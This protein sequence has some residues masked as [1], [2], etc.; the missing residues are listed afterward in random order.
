MKECVFLAIWI[1]LTATLVGRTTL[2][3]SSFTA[4]ALVG[5]HDHPT[6]DEVTIVAIMKQIVKHQEQHTTTTNASH[7][8]DDTEESDDLRRPWVS[9]CF[10]QSLDGKLAQ[11]IKD[12]DSY[13]DASSGSSCART[14]SNLAISGASSLLLTHALRSAHDGILIGGRTLST[15][16]PRL[17][18]RF[19]QRNQSQPRPVVLDPH[20]RNYRLLGAKRRSKNVIVCHSEEIDLA[21]QTNDDGDT[22]NTDVVF[23]ACRVRQDGSLDLVDVLM[24]L[25]RDF[26]IESLMVEG[27]PTVLSLF[28]GAQLFDC[29]SITV[30][31]KIFG[32]GLGIS[33]PATC[34]VGGGDD[35]EVH[36]LED[37]L[38][39][40][41][42]PKH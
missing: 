9:L 25:R 15:D 5:D 42:F 6:A 16:N 3:S 30:A 2:A 32:C 13:A 14:T 20:L 19:W 39:L 35:L 1:T 23:L 27:G 26:G 36:R 18:N 7:E 24:K 37:D 34:S 10:A 41:A 31:P 33:L 21:S 12:D 8:D 40:L 4:S 29:V 22:D 28:F 11:F 17:S 38:C